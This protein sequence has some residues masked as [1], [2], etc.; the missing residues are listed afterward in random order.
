VIL[1]YIASGLRAEADRFVAPLRARRLTQALLLREL[2][3]G[4]VQEV[5]TRLALRPYYAQPFDSAEIERYC[6]GATKRIFSAAERAVAHEVDL[7]GSGPVH[8]GADIDWLSDLKTGR[9]WPQAYF[10]TIEYNNLEAPSDV[11]LAWELSRMQWL[12]PAGQAYILSRNE[13]YAECARDTILH[14]IENN[15]YA[16]SVNWACTMEVALRILTFTWL[17]HAFHDSAAWSD[18]A[19]RLRF[20]TAIYLHG[21]FTERYLEHS[22]INGNHYTAD[23]AGLVFVGLFLGT[24]KNPRRW[25]SLGWK[26]LES[27]L[28]RQVFADGVDFEASVPYHRLVFELFL[29]PAIYRTALGLTIPESYSTRLQAMAEFTEAYSRSDGSLPLWGDADDGRALPLG[30]AQAIND[31]RYLVGISA[32]FWQRKDLRDAFSGPVDEILWMFGPS[33]CE[34]LAKKDMVLRPLSKCFRS[35]GFFIMRNE[36]DHVFIDCGPIGLAGRGG[37]GHND[38]L[39]FEAVLNGVHLISDCGAYVYTASVKERNFFRSTKCHNTPCVDGVEMNR[40]IR[41]DYLWTLHCEAIPDFKEYSVGSDGDV[42]EGSHAGYRKL[43]DPVTPVR[44]ILLDHKLHSLTIYDR[45]EGAGSHD[46]EIP[47]HLA[48]GV[49]AEIAGPRALRVASGLRIFDVVWT[50]RD[51]WNVCVEDARVSPSYGVSTS[52]KRIVWRRQGALS[53]LE[54]VISP[55]AEV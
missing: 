42:F 46:V 8:L 20:L 55:I 18:E 50:S 3:A 19:F 11:K 2:E 17:F 53:D 21:Q 54:V 5:W 41:P 45:L 22:D 29:L 16:C 43:E 37:H 25:A 49:D 38:C 35:G 36:V 15:P 28:P 23:A 40:L 14:W 44:K 24:G 33:A 4:S 34:W 27:E 7:L 13:M 48:P 32:I 1:R 12:I 6:P 52:T 51:K 47:I 30:D 31:H 26:I 10:R 39:S 9:R